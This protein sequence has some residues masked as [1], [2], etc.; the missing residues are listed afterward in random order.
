MRKKKAVPKKVIEILGMLLLLSRPFGLAKGSFAEEEG[1]IGCWH[2][3]EGQGE[4][5][6]DSSGNSNHGK[7][8]GAQWVQGVSGKALRFDGTD[9]RVDCGKNI[10]TLTRNSSYT[11]EVWA[12]PSAP[13]TGDHYLMSFKNMRIGL[14]ERAWIFWQGTPGWDTG[15]RAASSSVTLDKWHHVVGVFENGKSIKLYVNG[16]SEPGAKTG[17]GWPKIGDTTYVGTASTAK[18]RFFAGAIDEVKIYNRVLSE[19]EIKERFNN[20]GKEIQA[21]KPAEPSPAEDNLVS[22]TE[23][24]LKELGIPYVRFAI[25]TDPHVQ[26]PNKRERR[27]QQFVEDMGRWKA[28]FIID[29]GDFA[30]QIAEGRTTPELHDGQLENLKR[31]WKL[32]SSGS[33][34]AYLVMGNHDVGWIKGGAEVIT[35]EDLYAG[36]HGGEDITKQEYLAVTG[37]PHRYYSF[38]VNG[39]HFIVLDG[40]DD[41]TVMQDVP[42]GHDHQI[43][44]GYCI[45][46][47]Q[48]AWLAQDLAAN[49]DKLKVVFCHEE[50]HVTPPEGS[51]EGGDAPFLQK[52]KLHSYVDNGWQARELLTADG[53]VLACFFGHKHRSRWVVYGGVNYITLA[54]MFQNDG[55]TKVTISDKLYIEGSEGRQRSYTLPIAA[56]L[57]ERTSR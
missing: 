1:L 18:K 53:N 44:G 19:K 37:L 10:T 32:Y 6:T 15:Y 38:D 45:D 49:R 31:A 16:I 57:Q 9:D 2:F 7:I 39:Y 43:Q 3:D 11:V 29:L 8:Q 24:Q 42:R 17:R 40:N 30:V 27:L 4:T 34:P 50:L 52:G 55:Y 48:L 13:L 41:P 36:S 35:P 28:D 56:R 23:E 51:G 21:S 54:A 20:P 22:P 14:S 25:S 46:R 33:C 12:N 26:S 47:K 5:A